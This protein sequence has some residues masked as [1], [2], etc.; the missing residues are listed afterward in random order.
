MAAA[1]PVAAEPHFGCLV[2]DGVLVRRSSWS[3]R[4]SAEL[5]GAG[6][7]IR[8]TADAGG[9]SS[10]C[11]S[12]WRVVVPSRLAII[13]DDCVRCA[14][15]VPAV[16]GAL[17]GRATRRTHTLALLLAVAQMRDLAGRLHS[18]LWHLADRWGRRTPQGVVLALPISQEVLG[19][20]AC[21][22][23]TSVTEALKTLE[24]RG[25]LERGRGRELVLLT[26]PP[27]DAQADVIV[28]PPT[29][30]EAQVSVG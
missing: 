19:A 10:D 22:K 5:I 30:G 15:A 24:G 8:L 4:C 9:P 23:R 14:A 16:L 27:S 2:L 25:V 1:D 20:L 7:L 11:E 6:D 3:Q 18:I 26:P 13:D 28:V 17:A 12:E 29:V 21:A